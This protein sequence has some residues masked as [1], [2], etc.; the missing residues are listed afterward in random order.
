MVSEQ[1]NQ[2]LNELACSLTA[3][4]AREHAKRWN[5]PPSIVRWSERKKYC[6]IDIGTSGAWLVEKDTGEIYNIKAYGVPDRNKKAKSDI[7][8][9][10]TVDAETMWKLRYNYLR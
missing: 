3:I 1:L 6:A 10:Y 5:T 7:G 9:A 2:R 4:E 8:N